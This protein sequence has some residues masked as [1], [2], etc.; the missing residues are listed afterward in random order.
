MY[1]T[2]GTL[3]EYR[4]P[5]KEPDNQKIFLMNYEKEQE[6]YTVQ[7]HRLFPKN[8]PSLK[9]IN[10]EDATETGQIFGLRHGKYVFTAQTKTQNPMILLIM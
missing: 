9:F 3:R 1:P 4:S 6:M 8:I 2:A 10:H 7:D 5:A